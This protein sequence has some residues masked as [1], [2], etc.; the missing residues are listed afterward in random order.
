M[1]NFFKKIKVGVLNDHYDLLGGG[2]VHS[3]KFIEY[4]KR[5][6]DV[7][8]N[9]PGTPKSK[10]WMKE[11]LHLDTEGLSFFPYVK[12]CGDKYDYLFLNVSH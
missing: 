2:T 12:G 4:L 1:N 7:E 10:E 8:V 3:F 11:F 6:Y 9:V 5:Y